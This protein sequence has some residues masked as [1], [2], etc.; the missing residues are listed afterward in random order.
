MNGPPYFYSQWFSSDN[1]KNYQEN[2]KDSDKRKLLEINGWIDRQ[3]DYRFNS[4]GFRCKDFNDSPSIVFLGCSHTVG[5]GI[6]QECTFAEIVAKEI[7]L[8]CVNL[9]IHASSLDSAYRMAT[10]WLPRLNCKFC[11]LLPPE[12]SRLELFYLDSSP[13]SL[14]AWVLD[15]PNTPKDAKD[16]YKIWAYNE[17]NLITNYQKNIDAINHVCYKNSI[18]LHI[19]EYEVLTQTQDLG[20]DLSHYGI[21]WNKLI[22]QSILSNIKI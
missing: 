8:N 14:S 13:L 7:N 18:P 9:G 5:V 3:F 16:F 4:H 19:A 1:E 12:N 6:P 15:L 17:N 20:R 22:A 21:K 10:H 2:L 11:V